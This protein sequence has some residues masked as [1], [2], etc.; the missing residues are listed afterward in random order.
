MKVEIT[1]DDIRIFENVIK[2]NY[3][4]GEEFCDNYIIITQ[5]EKISIIPFS[6]IMDFEVFND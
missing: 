6:E 3:Y 2:L 4:S 5:E 1:G